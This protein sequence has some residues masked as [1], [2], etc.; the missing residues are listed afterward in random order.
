ML[1]GTDD[2]LDSL[3]EQANLTTEMAT[4]F[5]DHQLAIVG[6]KGEPLDRTSSGYVHQLFIATTSLDLTV[7]F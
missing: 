3:S 6:K 2:F 7:R 5:V 1:R 4:D